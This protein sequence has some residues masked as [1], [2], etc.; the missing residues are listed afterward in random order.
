MCYHISQT[1]IVKEIER[2]FSVDLRDEKL[3]EFFDKPAFHINGFSHPKMLIIPQEETSVLTEA[4]WGIAPANTLSS[5]LDVYYKKSIKFGA[6]LNAQSEKLFDHFIY[7]YSALTRRCLIPVT[8]FFEPHEHNKKKYPFYIHKSDMAIF[9][10]AGIYTI[11]DRQVTFTVLTKEAS[12]FFA[13]I[14]NVRKRQ[15][16]ILPKEFEQEWLQD[17]L[18]K[19]QVKELLMPINNEDN[20]EAYTVSKNL[21]NPRID[22]DNTTILDKVN[23]LELTG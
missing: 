17:A 16:L 7:K 14:H 18:T 8:G 21:F 9:M 11:L 19:N 23:Y 5:N 4:I 15:P 1:K 20:F 6:G 2:K 22:S 12:P 10:L 3:R 13:R